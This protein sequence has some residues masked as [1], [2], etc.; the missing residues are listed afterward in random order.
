[1]RYSPE[2]MPLM[3]AYKTLLFIEIPLCYNY[4]GKDNERIGVV[5]DVKSR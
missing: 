2:G 5:D 4:D 1:M 3:L